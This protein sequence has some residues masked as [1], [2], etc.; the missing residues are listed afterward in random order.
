MVIVGAGVAGLS[1]AQWLTRFGHEPVVV[2]K[3]PELVVGGYKI[4]VRGAAIEIME[5]AGLLEA[6]EAAST[7]MRGA[8]LVDREGAEIAR[9]SGDDFGHRIGDDLEIVRGPLCRLLDRAAGAEVRYSTTVTGVTETP[10]GIEV[11]LSTGETFV[12]DALVGADGLHSA[13]RSLVFG[14]EEDF[15]RD[16]G[17]SLCVFSVPNHLGRDREELQYSELG[18][19]AAIWATATEP[20][21]KATFGF[22]ATD[23]YDRRDR[24]AQ[25]QAVREAFAGIGWEV[26]RLLEAM[27]AATDWYFD[28]AAQIEM[29]SWSSGRVVLV[30]D[31]AYCA[32]PM[33]GQGS[34]LALVGAYVLA[35]ELAS[36]GGDVVAAFAAYDAVLRPFVE[37]NQAL[38][39]I[40]AARM[41]ELEPGADTELSAE[42]IEAVLDST[43]DRIADAARAVEL[44]PYPV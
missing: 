1:L 26:P 42:Q 21:A 35:G 14:P 8:V 19:V 12:A 32:S 31:A 25:E 13:T 43:T 22:A 16:L 7:H 39:R 5:R 33:S 41:T 23:T 15:R 37:A 17:M 6:L 10:A 29:P 2:E 27:P 18:R 34:S 3:A 30:G 4:D 28:A 36:C 11:A 44:K 20:E 38:G 40:S 24:Q 9:M